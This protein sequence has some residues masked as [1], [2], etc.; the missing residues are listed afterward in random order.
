MMCGDYTVGNMN[1]RQVKLP[2]RL[3]DGFKGKLMV[4]AHF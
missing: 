2:N 3:L 1:A 4:A